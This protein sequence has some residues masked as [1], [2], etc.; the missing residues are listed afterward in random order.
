M[1]ASD[2]SLWDRSARFIS[3]TRKCSVLMAYTRRTVL[4][5]AVASAAITVAAGCLSG[6][7]DTNGDDAGDGDADGFEID[8]GSE[9]LFEGKTSGWVGLEPAEIEGEKNPT[10]VLRDGEDYEI[11]WTEG[12]GSRHNIEIWDDDGD[13]VEGHETA[14]TNDP[15]DDQLLSI[16]ATEEMAAYRCRPHSSMQGEIRVE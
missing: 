4:K 15:G 2:L 11:G 8:P 13:V 12:D 3:Y 5:A 1:F 6:G 9:I 7:D 16:T 14:L 10:L